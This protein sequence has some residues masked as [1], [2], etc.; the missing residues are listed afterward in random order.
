MNKESNELDGV[1]ITVIPEVPSHFFRN[2][3]GICRANER[4][5]VPDILLKYN[6]DRNFDP[7]ERKDSFNSLRRHNPYELL[8]SG[9]RNPS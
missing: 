4:E 6:L 2:Q 5:D 9:K 7:T 3:Y 8:D 1:K